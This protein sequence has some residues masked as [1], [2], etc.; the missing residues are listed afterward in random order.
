MAGANSLWG[1]WQSGD[2]SPEEERTVKAF[3]E[4]Y[5]VDVPSMMDAAQALDRAHSVEDLPEAFSKERGGSMDRSG[6]GQ[7]VQGA[8]QALPMV[9]GG[10]AALGAIGGGGGAPYGPGPGGVP[11]STGGST[12]LGDMLKGAGRWILDQGKGALSKLGGGN[13]L[14]GGGALA[15]LAAQMKAQ[16]DQRKSAEAFNQ[17]RL[18]TIMASLG[19]AEEEYDAR[20]PLR[21]QGQASAIQAMAAMG[22]NPFTA[23]LRRK[24]GPGVFLQR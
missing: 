16:S 12:G 11:A 20:A 10:Q 24:S 21:E 19:R 17:K 7:A 8:V 1:R 5:G 9:F 15:L 23:H 18:D 3:Y 6:I 22:Q 2:L 14:L 4:E 13:P